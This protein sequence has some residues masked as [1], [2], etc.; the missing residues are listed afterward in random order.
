MSGH[1]NLTLTVGAHDG[2]DGDWRKDAACRT[3]NPDWFE[4]NLLGRRLSADNHAA[5]RLCNDG[6]CPVRQIC[7][8]SW[9]ARTERARGGFIAGGVAWSRSSGEPRVSL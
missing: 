9:A 8:D 4:V 6:P 2:T 7:Y 3:T 5:L 1:G